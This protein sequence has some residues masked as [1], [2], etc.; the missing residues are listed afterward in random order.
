[1]PSYFEFVELVWNLRDLK[2][3]GDDRVPTLRRRL[4]RTQGQLEA[5][6]RSAHQAGLVEGADHMHLTTA[7]DFVADQM[8]IGMQEAQAARRTPY[9]DP[10]SY[11]PKS[12][13]P[14]I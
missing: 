6:L 12:W 9:R 1:M 13:T 7:G 5:L 3:L 4:R 14:S 10:L 2:D 11:L 8:A